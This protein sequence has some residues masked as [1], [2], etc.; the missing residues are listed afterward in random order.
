MS[1]ELRINQKCF[2][3]LPS[4]GYG[5]ES[6]KSCFVA[7]PA[8]DIYTLQLE[9]IKDIL[10]SK[11]YECHIALKRIDPGN[12]AF[13]TKICSKIIQSQ[14]CIVLLDPSFGVKNKEFPNPNVHMEYG[15]MLSQNK[16]IIPLQHEKNKLSFNIAPLD[17]IKYNDSNF[18][19]KVSDSVDNA[20]NRFSA[21]PP[22][23]QLR[24][25]SDMLYYNLKGY[26]V[27]D[28][29]GN[30]FFKV[31][32][33]FG[34]PLGFYF[35]VDTVKSKY[36]YVAPFANEDSRRIILHTKLLIE[37]IITAHNNFTS[38]LVGD[39]TS[40]DY[41]YM[42]RDITIDLIIPPFYDKSEVLKNLIKIYDNA[43]KYKIDIFYPTDFEKIINEE[44]EKIKELPMKKQANA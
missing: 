15:M 38:N 9:V 11:Q 43:K 4:C 16:H 1:K 24:P 19:K 6:A 42:L 35:F 3:G 37:N 29:H 44:Y 41:E 36:K 40:K 14:F 22:T 5:Y 13:C 20:I 10:E 26:I 30:S 7:A 8:D 39:Y 27:A 25:G 2:I 17:T 28:V 21:S 32:Y 18:K 34:Q 31:L 23:N 33:Q 12:F